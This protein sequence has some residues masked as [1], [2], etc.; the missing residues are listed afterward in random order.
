L[1]LAFAVAQGVV[2]GTFYK[3]LCKLAC[4]GGVKIVPNTTPY[5]PPNPKHSPRQPPLFEKVIAIFIKRW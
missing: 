2:L 4:T 1:P 3:P 5:P